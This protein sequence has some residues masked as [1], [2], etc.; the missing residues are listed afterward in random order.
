MAARLLT[1]SQRH[2][3]EIAARSLGYIACGPLRYQQLC[4]VNL[5]AFTSNYDESEDSSGWSVGLVSNIEAHSGYIFVVILRKGVS[6]V[7]KNISKYSHLRRGD[8][9]NVKYRLNIHAPA[10]YRA[11]HLVEDLKPAEPLAEVV[12]AHPKLILKTTAKVE[13]CRTREDNAL[14]SNEHFGYFVD[15]SGLV[16]YER[17]TL[18]EFEFVTMASPRDRIS[19][20]FVPTRIIRR[21]ENHEVDFDNSN[22]RSS[23]PRERTD[24]EFERDTR[25]SAVVYS[26]DEELASNTSNLRI[27]SMDST[28]EGRSSY[29]HE[30]DQDNEDNA[31]EERSRQELKKLRELAARMM[32]DAKLEMTKAISKP[33][34]IGV[35][36]GTASGKSLVTK[37]IIQRLANNDQRV[38]SIQLDS[39]YKDVSA[40]QLEQVDLGEYDFDH[41]SAFDF[42]LLADVLERLIIG[43]PVEIPNYDILTNSRQGVRTV[44][45][46]DVVIVEGILVFYDERI[47]QLCS[48]KLFVDAD[49]DIRLSRR[50]K[51]DTGER[52]RPLSVVLSHYVNKV[53]PAFEEF[54]LP[55]KRYADVIIPRGGENDV[56]IDLIVENLQDFFRSSEEDGQTNGKSPRPPVELKRSLSRPH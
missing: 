27:C 20:I 21:I 51:K 41:P 22:R 45:P 35:A 2:V 16:R 46:A 24:D 50:V 9:L 33:H 14:L 39:F 54:C 49:A 42:D 55:T 25:S 7:L 5:M 8:F 12:K 31:K 43:E 36:G 3:D 53:K 1:R 13:K 32:N 10:H 44:E 38:I 28:F 23:K 47:R 15:L 56:A 11:R 37:K 18:V 29:C 48:T 52:K 19:S 30:Q 4:W 6:A 40:A 26:D 34:I 17:G